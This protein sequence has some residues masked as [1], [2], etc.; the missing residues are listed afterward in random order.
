MAYKGIFSF[1]TLNIR[2]PLM[3][4]WESVTW[5]CRVGNTWIGSGGPSPIFSGSQ[6]TATFCKFL[7][8]FSIEGLLFHKGKECGKTNKYLLITDITMSVSMSI[9][10]FV[11]K[12][13]E[14]LRSPQRSSRVTVQNQEM[15]VYAVRL[16]LDIT[17]YPHQIW[18]GWL[19]NN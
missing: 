11:A 14:L 8:R 15:I 6:Y 9:K 19:N 16:T 18:W 13:A 4:I 12:I 17:V 2:H 1:V 5:V 7:S 10:I 3:E